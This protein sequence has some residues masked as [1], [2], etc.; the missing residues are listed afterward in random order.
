[1]AVYMKFQGISGAVT[2]KGYEK[3]VELNSFSFGLGRSIGTAARGSVNREGAEPHFSEVMITKPYDVAS[4]KLIEDGWGGHLDSKVEFKFTTTVKDGVHHFLS[5]ELE[6]CGVSGYQVVSGDQGNP[7]ESIALN[8][9][10]I[11]VNH[12]GMDSKGSGSP[13]RAAYDLEK[14]AKA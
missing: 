7:T 3:W 6:K 1:M 11:T 14:M 8:Y 2:T 4:I 12:I 5:I 10:K 13:V 9:A